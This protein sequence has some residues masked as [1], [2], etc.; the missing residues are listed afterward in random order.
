MGINMAFRILQVLS[1]KLIRSGT[2]AW[3]LLKE[4]S[5]WGALFH[6]CSLIACSLTLMGCNNAEGMLNPLRF[7]QSSNSVPAGVTV[8]FCTDPPKTPSVAL[9]TLFVLDHSLSNAKNYQLQ[10]GSST[11]APA[12][13]FNDSAIYATDP[14]GLTRYGAYDLTTNTPVSGLLKYLYDQTINPDP[15]QYFA[16]ID[17]ETN[18]NQIGGSIYNGRFTNNMNTNDPNNFYQTVL[19]DS[20]LATGGNPADTG[21][22]YY[23]RALD[24]AAGIIKTDINDARLCAGMVSGSAPTSSCPVPGNPPISSYIVIFISD[25]APIVSIC[26]TGA[27]AGCETPPA[28]MTWPYAIHEDTQAILGYV[29]EMVDLVSPSNP[30]VGGVNMY[31]AYYYVIGNEDPGA[32]SLL[33]SMAYIG[34]GTFNNV[35]GGAVINYTQFQPLKKLAS[36]SLS[37]IF[38]SNAS[39]TWWKDGALHLDSDQDGLPDDIEN[40]YHSNPNQYSSSGNGIGDLVTYQLNQGTSYQPVSNLGACAPYAVGSSAVWSSSDPSGLNDC[41]KVLL[42]NAAGIGKPDSNGDFIPDWLEF[43]NFVPF[44]VGAPNAAQNNGLGGLTLYEDIKQFLP[45]MIAAG[46]LLNPVPVNYNL[47]TV[48]QTPVQTCY[49]LNAQNLPTIGENNTV[50][51]DIMERSPLLSGSSNLRTLYH[52]G[53][54]AFVGSSLLL[55]FNDWNDLGEI[56]AGTWKSWP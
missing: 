5:P 53:K 21:D 8:N 49:L 10:S 22:T 14:N 42:G 11:G 48:S 15:N 29:T 47:K 33:S 20:H 17:F 12:M 27:Y 23:T 4:R 56:A 43:K 18:P 7:A 45:T 50:R 51:I 19:S 34:N 2:S 40:A 52:V 44:Q 6:G 37:D 1:R 39:V 55:N 30:Y 36:Y 31:T 13:P 35:V 16:L 46:Q 25:G 26:L 32:Q 3:E 28:G 38:V 54:K 24:M 9:K 41:E